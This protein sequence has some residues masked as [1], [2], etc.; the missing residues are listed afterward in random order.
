MFVHV[1]TRDEPG[2][3]EHVRGH[4]RHSR[5]HSGPRH[6]RHSRLRQLRAAI[7][8]KVVFVLGHSGPR[9]HR[10]PRLRPLRAGIF[11][12]VVFV[13]WH[14]GPRHYR[15]SRLRQL[16]AEIFFKVVFVFALILGRG[17]TG[18]PAFA[19]WEQRYFWKSSVY[20]V[21]GILGR[22]ITGIPA[23]ANWEQRYFWKSS[24]YWGI[25]SCTECRRRGD[26]PTT[27]ILFI[28]SFALSPSAEIRR[29]WAF[30]A[31]ID[32]YESR[33]FLN[34]RA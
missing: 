2:G 29:S 6:H 4:A 7:F 16:R 17:I 21:F 15:H 25:F 12:K 34:I 22:G 1:Q 27:K 30:F 8:L 5:A 9:H 31:S 28:T 18:I 20:I 3:G 26:N 14:S 24:L 13:F 10:H 11:L 32:V 33:L 23:F 19:N